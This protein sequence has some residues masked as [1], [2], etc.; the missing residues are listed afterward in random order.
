MHR[1][2]KQGQVSWEEFRDTAQQCRNGVRKVKAWKEPN[3][4]RDAKNSKKGF[5]R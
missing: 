5:Y 3:L 1:Q 2:W 4:A